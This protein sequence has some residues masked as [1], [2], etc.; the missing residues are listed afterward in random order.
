MEQKIFLLA[1]LV[2]CISIII[3]AAVIF[4][5]VA[6]QR[7][8]KKG[9]S[10]LDNE[11]KQQNNDLLLRRIQD[12]DE[13]LALIRSEI[14]KDSQTQH[15]TLK[16]KLQKP[17]Y[18]LS[19][20]WGVLSFLG[21]LIIL[22]YIQLAFGVDYFE[23]FRNVSVDRNLSNFYREQG[24][25]MLSNLDLE[26]AEGAYRKALEINP[27]NTLAFY[28]LAGS[29]IFKPEEG[30]KYA[31]MQLAEKKLDFLLSQRPN[32][33]HL[34]I[35]KAVLY[36]ARGDD[37]N[38][39]LWS[40]KA[41]NINPNLAAGYIELGYIKQKTDIDEAFNLF[42]EAVEKDPSNV[43]AN[44]NLGYMYL[45][46]GDYENARKHLE[47]ANYFSPKLI[48]WIDLGDLAL[49]TKDTKTAIHI[50][51]LIQRTL[52][53]PDIEKNE[54]FIKGTIL[55]NCMPVKLGDRETI[56]NH[57]SFP[58]LD[59]KKTLTYYDLSFAYALN[60]D[61]EKADDLFE[62]ANA[63]DTFKSHNLF[64]AAKLVSIENLLDTNNDINSWIDT[65]IQILLS[66]AQ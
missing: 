11:K 30:Q 5:W 56:K 23:S 16:S 24:D 9:K 27:R 49:Y 7:R 8:E 38:A 47:T 17:F 31:D 4:A 12:I 43:M 21:S 61:F 55:L 2:G 50:F 59:D 18:F 10:S 15:H 58:E 29:E 26:A 19:N 60:N 3:F 28:G 42:K 22:V 64:F 51:T 36:E 32:D 57:D 14:Q 34:Y 66:Q 13:E 46:Q 25:I 33:Y 41:I 37:E 54:N 44:N 65:H 1:I 20:H 40:E 39:Q 35:L 6:I 48:T 63:L 45:I 53:D 62:K 52:E